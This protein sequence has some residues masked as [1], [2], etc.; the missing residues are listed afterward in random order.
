MHI[1]MNLDNVEMAAT[2]EQLSEASNRPSFCALVSGALSLGLGL[3][4]TIVGL[5]MG[6]TL[7]LIMLGL[8]PIALLWFWYATRRSPDT[9]NPIVASVAS[10]TQEHNANVQTAPG[11]TGDVESS[12]P[13]EPQ[14]PTHGSEGALR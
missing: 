8:M 14:P 6:V 13:T 3:V 5:M 4:V 7:M 9:T 10:T 12:E 11:G 2:A 1:Q